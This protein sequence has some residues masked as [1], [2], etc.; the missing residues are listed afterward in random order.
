M[1]Q[2]AIEAMRN[3]PGVG[4]P[5]VVCICGSSRFKDEHLAALASETLR[6]KIVLIRGFF[7]HQDSVPINDG[8]KRELDV[9]HLRKIDMSD[10]IFIVNV[11]G[12]VGHS[13]EREIAYA[14]A[15]KKGIRWLEPQL[16]E[17]YLERN[18]H[19]LGSLVAGFVSAA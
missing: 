3:T 2:E 19:G 6:G 17:D 10:E 7:H 14:I 9:L 12:Y 16:G 11:G 15:T 5:G 18:A 1:K 8:I 13:T 4:R